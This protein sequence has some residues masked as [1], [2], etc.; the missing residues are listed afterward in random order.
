MALTLKFTVENGDDC[1]SIIFTETTGAYNVTTNPT[2]WGTPN[3]TIAQVTE[4]TLTIENLTTAV[5]YDDITITPN[6]T[7][8]STTI[9]T[10]DL[11]VGGVSIGDITLPDGLYEFT[12]TVIANTV[13]YEQVVKSL[14][15]CESCC[16][17]KKLAADVDI[18][19]GCCNDDCAKELYQFLEAHTL[20]K[21]LQ[22]GGICGSESEINSNILSLQE[23]LININCKNC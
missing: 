14:F 9:T 7:N 6:S 1:K 8:S 3:A 10:Q 17:I 20:Y 16:K 13:T 18:N 15:L 4:A 5:I 22:W 21:A 23:F 12:Y 11:E 19:C 2:G